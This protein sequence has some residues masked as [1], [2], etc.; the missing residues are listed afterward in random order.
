MLTVPNDAATDADL[1]RKKDSYYY[2][3]SIERLTSA[4]LSPPGGR[5]P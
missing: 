5:C 1:L 3:V 2:S 4:T